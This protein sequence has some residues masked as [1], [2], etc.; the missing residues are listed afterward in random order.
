MLVLRKK[1]LACFSGTQYSLF[2]WAECFSKD[3]KLV[4]FAA[5]LH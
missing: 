2:I 5:A 4:D 1:K 3:N